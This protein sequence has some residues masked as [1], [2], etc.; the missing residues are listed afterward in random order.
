MN[1]KLARNLACP[2]D[3]K[4]L[5]VHQKSL[6]CE[7]GHL[8]DIARQGYVNLLPVQYKRSKQPGDS[9]EMVVARAAFLNSG[10]Y[11]PIANKLAELVYA[12]ITED[13]ETCV[14]DAGC[15]EGYYL[16]YVFNYLNS[17]DSSTDV[18]FI[19]MD[20]SK[21]AIVE[22]TKRNNQ[23]TWI[24]GTNRQP[25]VDNDSVDVILCV[26]GFHSLEAFFEKLKVGGKLILVDPGPDHLQ[27]LRE[28]IYTDVKR[29]KPQELANAFDIGFSLVDE[30][31]LLFSTGV[32]NNE[33]INKLLIMTPHFY[34]ASKEGRDAA[35]KLSQLELTVD[36]A[37]RMLEKKKQY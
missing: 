12:Q 21:S 34:R 32:I 36:V 10:V 4:R 26:F 22:S 13:G 17:K 8:F 6:R 18:S 19:G 37:I 20:I 29:S 2:I 23:I 24:V 7:S 35:S 31:L 16:D 27:E 14:M 3:G 28:I 1:S 5:V 11:E 15:G 30:Q 9:K 25:P 33:L